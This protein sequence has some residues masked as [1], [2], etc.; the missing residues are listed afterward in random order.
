[1]TEHLTC[2]RPDRDFPGT[3]C[4]YPL[5]CPHHTIILNLDKETVEIPVGR[6]T[7]VLP[8]EAIEDSTIGK[9]AKALSGRKG[10][11]RRKAGRRKA[12]RRK[13]P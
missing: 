10:T 4:G 7:L 9:I 11:D 12:D 3:I 8:T 6:G 13:K 1:M 5:P 2:R